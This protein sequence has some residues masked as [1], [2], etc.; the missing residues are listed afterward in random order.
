M[1]FKKIRSQ[2]TLIEGPVVVGSESGFS[3]KSLCLEVSR[4]I[5]EKLTIEKRKI[6][7]NNY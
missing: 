6:E 1:I 2:C 4:N 7:N 3:P 5:I